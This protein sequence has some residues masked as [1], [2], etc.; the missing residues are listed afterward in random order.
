[1]AS[2]ATFLTVQFLDWVK[3]RPRTIADIRDAWTSTCPLNSAWEDAIAD[4]LVA[5]EPGGRLLLT[6]KGR[7]RLHDAR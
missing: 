2:Q 1:M 7:A 6:A 3:D 4:D 5:F